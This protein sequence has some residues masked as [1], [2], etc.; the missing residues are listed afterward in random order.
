MKIYNLLFSLRK[1]FF[2]QK[3]IK[4]CGSKNSKDRSE[5]SFFINYNHPDYPKKNYNHPDFNMVPSMVPSIVNDVNDKST[6]VIGSQ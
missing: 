1:I 3:N 2:H 5:S 6:C 4:K